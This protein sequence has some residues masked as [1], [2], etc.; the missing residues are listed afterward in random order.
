MRCS[1]SSHPPFYNTAINTRPEFGLWRG[2]HKRLV[3]PMHTVS[4]SLTLEVS[5][6]L[7]SRLEKLENRLR[8]NWRSMESLFVSSSLLSSEASKERLCHVHGRGIWH[9]SACDWRSISKW[10]EHLK[11]AG[12]LEG[13]QSSQAII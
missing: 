13:G 9:I 8:Y 5:T 6:P 2:M 4:G 12:A 11:M 1:R 7:V 3:S 10:L